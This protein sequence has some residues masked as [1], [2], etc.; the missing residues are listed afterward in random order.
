MILV[1]CAESGPTTIKAVVMGHDFKDGD[2]V[3]GQTTDFKATDKLIY[4]VATV[5]GDTSAGKVRFVW[6]QVD[7][8]AAQNQQFAEVTVNLDN[9]EMNAATSDFKPNPDKN[10]PTGKYKV[11]VYLNDQLAKTVE[12]TVS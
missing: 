3:V 6:I 12:F 7:T 8:T 2:G 11:D 5:G 4:C 1:G 9:K 10:L